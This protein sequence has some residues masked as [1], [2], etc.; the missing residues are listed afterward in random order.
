M[1]ILLTGSDGQLG[2]E[3]Q[4]ALP[5]L[6]TLLACD[7]R[8]C[9]LA[10]AQAVRDKIRA[11]R[12]NVIVNAA[13][14]TAVDRAE[15]ELAQAFAVN[16]T[17]PAI[18]GEEAERLGALVLHYSSDYVFN[19]SGEHFQRETDLTCPATAYGR[20]KLEGEHKLALAT[21]RHLIFRTSWVLGPEGSNFARTMLRLAAERDGIDVVNDQIGAPTTTALI[22]DVT[23]RAIRHRSLKPGVYHLAAAGQT[24]WHTYACRVIETARAAGHRIK[25]AP[26]AVRAV[27]SRDYPATAPRPLNSRLDTGKL[28]RALEIEFDDWRCG[29]DHVLQQIL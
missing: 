20:S 21:E 3:L 18:L 4:R 5:L 16:A 29:V 12:P 15:H 8:Q 23:L 1:R 13:A 27:S 10:D 19:G 22:T 9:D 17:A 26:D 25:V 6:G 11:F 28:R 24:S 14:Y 2:R 7:R